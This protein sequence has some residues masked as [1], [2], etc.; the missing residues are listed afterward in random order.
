MANR[1]AAPG[2]GTP[3][4]LSAPPAGDKPPFI[5][6]LLEL[7]EIILAIGIIGGAAIGSLTYF[8]TKHQLEDVKCLLQLNLT[9][10]ESRMD[11]ADL[12]QLLAQNFDQTTALEGKGLPLTT[13]DASKLN[14]LKAAASE[15]GRKL[16]STNNSIAEAMVRLK[17]GE[18][19]TK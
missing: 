15:I 1:T 16:A 5:K 19:R 14:Q 3:R 6:T 13:A 12:N 9:M 4:T 18:C 10:V 2:A 11:A 7:K 8:A 17:R